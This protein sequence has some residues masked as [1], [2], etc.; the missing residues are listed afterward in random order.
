M[1]NLDSVLK[2]KHITLT[3]K[4]CIVKAMIFPVLKYRWESWTIK[5]AECQGIYAFEVW[6]W[7]GLLRVPWTTRWSNQSILNEINPEYSLEG[8][9]WS[10]KS[11]NLTIWFKELTHWK[12]LMLRKIEGKRRRRWQRMRWLSSFTNSMD[13]NFIN[14]QEIVEDK[15][16]WLAM[17]HGVTKSQTYLNNWTTTNIV[18]TNDMVY[19]GGL[20]HVLLRELI[21]IYVD[22]ESRYLKEEEGTNIFFYILLS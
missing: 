19:G 9:C 3:S 13:M 4:V 11:N 17:V 7:G 22:K 21:L 1:K 18:Y 14:L 5:R 16:A 15:R 12:R 6:C 10:W 2:S 8:W 20:G